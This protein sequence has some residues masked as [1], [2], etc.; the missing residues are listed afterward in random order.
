MKPR[1]RRIL[2]MLFI[3]AMLALILFI[4]F[5]NSELA[6]AWEVLFTLD[7][8]WVLAAIGCW[9]L[10]YVFDAVSTHYFLRAQGYSIKFTSA[11]YVSMTGFFY[12]NITPGSSGGQPL[13]VYAL[14][15]RG[16]PV[17]IGT[18]AI[19]LRFFSMQVMMI[20][21]STIFWLCNRAFVDVQLAGAK[22]AI[23]IG[24]AINFVAIPGILLVAF[25]RPLVVTVTTWLIRLLGKLRILKK[26]DDT[27]L[28]VTSIIDGYHASIK[29]L[30][31]HPGHILVQLLYA[32]IS[33]VGLIGVTVCVY[34][35]FGMTG[36]PWHQVMTVSFL[37][38]LSASY[39]PLPGAS[40]A[41][42]GGFLVFFRGMFTQGTIGLAL[43]VWRFITY[44][45]FLLSGAVMSIVDSIRGGRRKKPIADANDEPAD[46][47][48]P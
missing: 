15:K 30:G 13:Q 6:N 31:R 18:S 2:N 39:T 42:E 14:S 44:Y 27:L 20:L 38:F 1:T 11:L 41:Q 47:P 24:W 9:L 7:A 22:W 25:C 8:R 40:G 19:S 3:V 17:A 46:S 16:V 34:E 36:R 21:L 33:V 23:Y 35:A 29:R 12:A 32:G 43:L 5:G 4:A 26:P 48:A 37:L 28:R 10:Y 45:L